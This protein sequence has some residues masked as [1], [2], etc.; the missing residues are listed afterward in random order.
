[1]TKAEAGPTPAIDAII[2]IESFIVL[3]LVERMNHESR[4]TNDNDATFV[5]ALRCCCGGWRFPLGGEFTLKMKM[6]RKQKTTST[7]I[8]AKCH[9]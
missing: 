7:E 9:K 4:G 5:G 2:R 8:D 1:M 3:D 6:A